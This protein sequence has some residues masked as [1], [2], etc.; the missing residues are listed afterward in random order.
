VLVSWLHHEF[1]EGYFW[2]RICSD[3]GDRFCEYSGKAAV[4]G[5]VN[6][7][8]VLAVRFVGIEREDDLISIILKRLDK[9]NNVPDKLG[10]NVGLGDDARRMHSNSSW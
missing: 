10:A 9:H 6:A 8:L 1:R 2:T 7:N 5:N 3:L 4:N